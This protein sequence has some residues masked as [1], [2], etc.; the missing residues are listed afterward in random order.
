MSSMVCT[1]KMS[2]NFSTVL[3]TRRCL[4]LMIVPSQEQIPCFIYIIRE[5]KN[6][7]YIIYVYMS[8][9]M[10]LLSE[11]PKPVWYLAGFVEMSES[12][13]GSDLTLRC[14]STRP[15]CADNPLI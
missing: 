9:V 13:M 2:S 12:D 3:K 1:H 15:H 5:L 14:K 7:Y 6:S 10:R 8:L 4:F 11:L